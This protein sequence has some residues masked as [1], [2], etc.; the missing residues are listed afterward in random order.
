[1][2]SEV[3]L[4]MQRV[5]LERV[6]RPR[7]TLIRRERKAETPADDITAISHFVSNFD[8]SVGTIGLFIMALNNQLDNLATDGVFAITILAGIVG[9]K[10][11]N[12]S[13]Q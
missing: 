9:K 12:E 6:S 3:P 13:N 8:I 2:S 11:W 5:I 4:P 7:V 1:M 10:L